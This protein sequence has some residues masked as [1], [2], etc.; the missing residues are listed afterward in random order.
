MRASPVVVV[1]TGPAGL[2]AALALGRMGVGAVVA[3]PLPQPD[4]LAADTRT[5]ALFGPSVVLMSRLGAWAAMA[6]SAEPILGLR[7]ID[8]TGGLLRAPDALF[9]A[10]QIGRDAFGA[11]IAN[12]AIV[13][14]LYAQARA[15]PAITFS[16]ANV[17]ALRPAEACVAVELETGATLSASLVV[18]ADGR[19]SP[20]RAA[21]G[22]T[23]RTWG[24]PQ[25]AIVTSFSHSRAHDGIST[26]LHRSAGPFTTVPLPDGRSS[27]VW[28]ERPEEAR[29]LA[30]LDDAVLIDAIETR[31]MGLLGSVSRLGPRA[32]YPLSSAIA[33]PLAARRIALVG[34]AG[35]IFPP[36]G[37]QGL[38]LGLRDV[39]HLASL[40]AGAVGRGEDPGSPAVLERYIEARRGDVAMRT[41]AVDALNRTLI[42]GALPLDVLRGA[43]IAALSAIGPLRDRIV[44]AGLGWQADLPD[45]MR[46]GPPSPSV[47][48]LR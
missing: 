1:G 41:Y 43:G 24:Y 10:R 46:E 26:E 11:N 31:L 22:I 29:R 28:V 21:A 33:E 4:L 17:A 12:A 15:E 16:G 23:C 7:L 27:L 39:A 19:A 6:Q 13:Q 42:A 2:A 20:S 35:H 40:V 9:T 25:T 48:T 14:A 38:N 32:T 36:I 8:D 47:A 44:E 18:G 5:A 30:G 3:G 37:A 45:L 34:E